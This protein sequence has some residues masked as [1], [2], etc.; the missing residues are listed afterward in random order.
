MRILA[1]PRQVGKTTKAIK[2]AIKHNYVLVCFNNRLAE[3]RRKQHPLLR[4]V[5][6]EMFMNQHYTCGRTDK[7]VIDD[8]GLCLNRPS[9]KIEMIT[10]L[11][12]AI[13]IKRKRKFLWWG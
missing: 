13:N 12:K 6:L 2:Y 9:A 1:G 4:T 3:Q 10:V 5:G 7:Y 11:G 8:I